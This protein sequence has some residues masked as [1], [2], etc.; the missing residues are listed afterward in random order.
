MDRFSKS[1]VVGA[2]KAIVGSHSTATPELISAFATAHAWRNGHLEPLRRV[3]DELSKKVRRLGAGRLAVGRLK[4]FQS[5]RRKLKTGRVTLYQMQDIGGVRAIVPTMRHVDALTAQYLSGK[6]IHEYCDSDDYIAQPKPDGYRSRHIIVKFADPKGIAGGNRIVIEIQIRTHLQHA[7][8]TAVEA[9]GFVRGENLKGGQGDREWLRFF[10]LV[11]G[12]F[13]AEEGQPVGQS[14]P[15][16]AA[17]RLQELREVADRIGAVATLESYNQA[18]KS[19]E[20]YLGLK[21]HSYIIRYDVATREV[22]VDRFAGFAR[23]SDQKSEEQIYDE[24][25][26][27]IIV[28]I[29]K[30]DDLRSAYPNYFLDVRM[31][32]DRLKRI[33]LDAE[34]VSTGQPARV[35]KWAPFL[36]FL[37]DYRPSGARS[38]GSS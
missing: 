20:G 22:T 25:K 27:L 21:G 16:D 38:R 37:R 30:V 33:V 32:T 36:D 4:R 34:P 7:W 12:E 6:S 2:G 5:I 11:S 15:Q 19:T 9:V 8:A 29:D 1:Q 31:F 14:V 17:T 13:A 35:L 3:R 26:N 24:T 10:E 23:L 18:I 28:E